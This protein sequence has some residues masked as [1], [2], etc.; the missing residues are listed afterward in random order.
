MRFIYYLFILN[1]IVFWWFHFIL[2]EEKFEPCLI[3]FYRITPL[4]AI[5]FNLVARIILKGGILYLE[6]IIPIVLDCGP[7]WLLL[8]GWATNLQIIILLLTHWFL[9]Q[10]V[11]SGANFNHF[12][13]HY[14]IV[15]VGLHFINVYKSL[16]CIDKLSWN[17]FIWFLFY[18][19]FI[20]APCL[21]TTIITHILKM[22]VF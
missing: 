20:I 5:Q 19:F 3:I 10:I 18:Q 21:R 9:Y 16:G 1:Q 6:V 13:L 22:K 15:H 8:M 4:L 2:L 14:A 17:I 11:L 7:W 12:T